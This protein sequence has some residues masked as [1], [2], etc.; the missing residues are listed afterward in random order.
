MQVFSLSDLAYSVTNFYLAEIW[1]LVTA[2]L[3]EITNRV[4]ERRV[5]GSIRKIK[6]FNSLLY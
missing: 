2:E 5:L 1:P 6:D 3:S 4:T